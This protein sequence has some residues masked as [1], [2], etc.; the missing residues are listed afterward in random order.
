MTTITDIP[1]FACKPG[2]HACCGLVAFSPEEWA[3]VA[4]EAARRGI[5][6]IDCGDHTIPEPKV[7]LSCPFLESDGCGIY[8]N[9]PALCRLFGA[10]DHP[11]MQ[12]PEGCGPEKKL[13]NKVASKILHPR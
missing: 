10:V 6:A 5:K 11:L 4:Q 7:G 12:C 2:C 9:R 8:E 3:S 13:S 1:T